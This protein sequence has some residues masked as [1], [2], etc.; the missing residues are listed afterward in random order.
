MPHRMIAAAAL[1]TGILTSAG[2]TALPA[3]GA[4]E[5]PKLVIAVQPT[6]TPPRPGSSSN[7]SPSAPARTSR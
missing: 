7:S 1:L 6:A 4:A 5:K 2:L 3:A